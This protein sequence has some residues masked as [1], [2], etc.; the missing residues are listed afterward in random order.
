[1]RTE[2][3]K[4]VPGFEG[5]YKVST[6]GNI[7]SFGNWGKGRIMKAKPNKQEGYRYVDLRKPGVRRMSKVSHLVA[8]AFIG[9][10][11]GLLVCHNN[12][13]RADDRLENL[14]YDTQAGNC[15]DKIKH[16]TRQNGERN[17]NSK[18]CEADIV[19]IRKSPKPYI[20][21][22]QYGISARHVYTI[23]NRETWSHVP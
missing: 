3:W 19:A 10:S 23:K 21:A 20:I 8:L 12:G 16:G 1:M 9:P 4:D 13:N 5:Y 15:A 17:P 14:R 22:K 11:N 2:T 7:R 6:L 18:L